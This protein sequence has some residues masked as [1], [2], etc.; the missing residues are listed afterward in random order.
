MT[1][2]VDRACELEQ[3][4]REQALA[5]AKQPVEQPNELEGHRYCLDCDIEL[6][7]KRLVAN[8][9]AVRCV[10]CQTLHEHQQKQFRGRY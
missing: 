1:D 4:Q 3:K 9:N 5:A 6:S 10:D 2:T 7:V 8:P